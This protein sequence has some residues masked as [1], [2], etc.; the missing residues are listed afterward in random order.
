M[1]STLGE[2][3]NDHDHASTKERIIRL[4]YFGPKTKAMVKMPTRLKPITE[5]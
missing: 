2:L 5:G 3:M 4:T 1:S